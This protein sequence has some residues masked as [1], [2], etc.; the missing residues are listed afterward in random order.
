MRAPERRSCATRSTER[1][2]PHDA[3]ARGLGDGLSQGVV[4]GAFIG[5]GRR[6]AVRWLDGS[7]ESESEAISVDSIEA[8]DRSGSWEW[9]GSDTRQ[10]FYESVASPRSVASA[11]GQAQGHVGVLFWVGRDLASWLACIVVYVALVAV[12][13]LVFAQIQQSAPGA[14]LAGGRVLQFVMLPLLACVMLVAGALASKQAARREPDG[15][16]WWAP[17]PAC[18]AVM[19]LITFV[20]YYGAGQWAYGQGVLSELPLAAGGSVPLLLGQYGTAILDRRRR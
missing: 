6:V 8:W 14:A 20:I 4:I 7:F 5:N 9:A 19:I 11:S 18:L 3:V 17:V 2:H 1:R 16:E 12:A 13:S 15:W 10:W